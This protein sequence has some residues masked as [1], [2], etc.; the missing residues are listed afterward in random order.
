M[1]TASSSNSK[2][3]R[4]LQNEQFQN[5]DFSTGECIIKE[6]IGV[7]NLIKDF[8]RSF[9]KHAE[10]VEKYKANLLKEF[11]NKN[12][13]IIFAIDHYNPFR[14][15]FIDEKS[16]AIDIFHF[17]R[18][19]NSIHESQKVDGII[20][21]DGINR[22][23]FTND[24]YSYNYFYGRGFYSNGESIKGVRVRPI[25]VHINGNNSEIEVKQPNE[26]IYE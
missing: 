8:C 16:N 11:P 15:Q 3:S 24:D 26:L 2:G 6:N 21:S 7:N 23:Y 20:Y 13:K 12:I 19:V 22:V 17:R 1:I 4:L 9:N 14:L 10:K 5:M 25:E 18:V